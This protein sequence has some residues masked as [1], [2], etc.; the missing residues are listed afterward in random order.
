M[1]VT[2][3]AAGDEPSD[4]AIAAALT[5]LR[6]STAF[7]ANPATKRAI[8]TLEASFDPDRGV[9]TRRLARAEQ[10]VNASLDRES[11]LRNALAFAVDL[12]SAE[13]GAI[14]LNDRRSPHAALHYDD[15]PDGRSQA[16][17][18]SVVA[19]V[20]ETGVP[21]VTTERDDDAAPG[22]SRIGG[23]RA[24][25]I[26][27]V[28]L[29]VRDEIAGAIYLDSRA[30]PSPFDHATTDTLLSFAR[31]TA[32]AVENARLFEDERDRVERI[33]ALQAFQTR[34][35]EAIA[36]GVITLSPGGTV[37]TFNRAAEITFGIPAHRM[38]GENASAIAAAVPDFPELLDMFYR[39]GAVQLRAETEAKRADG[40]TL[41][42]EMQLAPLANPEG[43][44][45]AI[46]V[47]DVTKQ[48]GL[49]LAH[50]ANVRKSG[51]IAESFSRYLAPHVV[52]SLMADPQSFS[53]G[54]ERG[55]ATMCFADV[56]GFTQMASQLE[57]ERVVEIL[58]AYFEEAVRVVFD[59]DGLLDKFYGDGMMAVFGPPRVREDDAARAVRAAVRLHQAVADLGPRIDYP[60]RIS[61]GLATGEV[62]AGHFGSTQRM[63]YTVI[64]DAVN[65]ANGLQA[66][67]PPGTIYCDEA[68]MR[69][70]GAIAAPVERRAARIKGRAD[71]VSVFVISP[72]LES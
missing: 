39:S 30:V 20:L 56:R 60:L 5:L 64:G 58:N 31:H 65:L 61:V 4:D 71:L 2:L 70:A 6:T 34:I 28:P 12:T 13:R 21:V 47:N 51:L 45:V 10:L 3:H 8:E 27:C 59:H 62:V 35:L 7:A 55:M 67:A 43:V 42:V 19:S 17:S 46:V 33:S 48:R 63:D 14:F 29:R 72:Q 66:A 49:E 41:T 68:T 40:S 32:L 44:G 25:A 26:A 53:L 37:T 1:S 22:T 69:R 11:V 38:T 57:A 36:N 15:A 24:R 54:G 50:E 18:P 9:R 16:P 23:A 52:K